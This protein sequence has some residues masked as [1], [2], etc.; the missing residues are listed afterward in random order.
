MV[1][2]EPPLQLQ[3]LVGVCQG[4]NVQFVVGVQSMWHHTEAFIWLTIMVAFS[5]NL[6]RFQEDGSFAWV[7]GP[8]CITHSY[9]PLQLYIS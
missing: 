1:K 9:G 7:V 2:F 8:W 3:V 6:P 5:E 4:Y